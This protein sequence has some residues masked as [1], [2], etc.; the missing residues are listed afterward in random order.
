MAAVLS[1]PSGYRWTS[2]DLELHLDTYKD[3]F[4]NSVLPHIKPEWKPEDLESHVFESGVTNTLVAF[5]KREVGLQNS[6]SD[7]ILL[8]INGEGTDKIINRLDEVVTM[9]SLNEEGLCPPLLAELKNGL[10]YGYLP[11]RRLQVH[12]TTSNAF[13]M[14]RVARVMAKL[15]SLRVP[16]YFSGREPFLWLKIDALM[17]NVPNSFHDKDMQDEFLES[18]GSIDNLRVEIAATKE[19]ILSECNSPIVFC[20]ND[21]HSA[22]LIYN[23]ETD[24]INLVDYEYAGPNYLAYDIADHFCEFAGVENVNYEKYPN[25]MVQKMWI[26]TYFEEVEKLK[27]GT[28]E[29]SITDSSINNLY[30]DISKITLGCHLLWVVWSLFQAA[31]STIEFNYINYAALR[32]REYFRRKALIVRLK[33]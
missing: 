33:Q 32:Y 6:G 1:Q 22:N 27:G 30:S 29:N 24:C 2:L 17:M 19:L 26:Q 11:G 4:Y 31:H 15:H 16:Q 25:E 3:T 28:G 20:H 8:R 18:I 5:Y 12:E 14:S 7:V 13:I 10:C 23:E 9:I 21:I